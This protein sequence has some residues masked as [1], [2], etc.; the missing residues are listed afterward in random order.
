MCQKLEKLKLLGSKTSEALQ[1]FIKV[2]VFKTVN[3]EK[4][5]CRDFESFLHRAQKQF[6]IFWQQ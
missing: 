2:K 6:L 3:K 1:I 4:Q 5:V